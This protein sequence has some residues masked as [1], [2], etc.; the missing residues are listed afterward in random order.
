LTNIKKRSSISGVRK[1]FIFLLSVSLSSAVLVLSSSQAFADH[2]QDVLGL[3]SEP[4]LSIPP[5]VEGPGLVLPDSPL[6]FIDQLKQATRLLFAFTPEQ[7]MTIHNAVA[8]ERLAELQI[9]LAK[10]N[11]PG[12]RVAL[13]GVSDNL[14][15]ASEDLTNA[16]LTGRNVSLLAEELNISIKE[17]QKVMSAL[18]EQASGEIKAQVMA[19]I[20]A[21]KLAKVRTEVNL[22]ADLLANETVNDLYQQIN[23]GIS[24]ASLSAAEINRAIGVLNKFASSGAQKNQEQNL[25]RATG[26]KNLITELQKA[27]V[28]LQKEAAL[29]TVV[30]TVN[31]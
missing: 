13:Q 12:I 29:K 2:Q 24:S 10:N 31:K 22:P 19:T 4:T 11:I 27:S 18:E 6:Y 20:E 16:K 1:L 28:S 15:A 14:K 7:K 8:G 25:E 21:L 17:K 5:T 23:E 3:A 30:K 9:M 26:V